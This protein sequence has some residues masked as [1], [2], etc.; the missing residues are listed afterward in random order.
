MQDEVGGQDA[1]ALILSL[2]RLACLY[3]MHLLITLL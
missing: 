1:D 2:Y 3:N